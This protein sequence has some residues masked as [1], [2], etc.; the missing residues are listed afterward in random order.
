[1]EPAP[2]YDQ[3]A[4]PLLLEYEKWRGQSYRPLLPPLVRGL[5]V[6][7]ACQAELARDGSLFIESLTSCQHAV[8]GI[9]V[10]WWEAR[11][12]DG[13]EMGMMVNQIK[14]GLDPE[15]D[16]VD[17]TLRTF[18]CSWLRRSR[19]MTA[20]HVQHETE[21]LF[22]AL[23]AIHGSHR[24]AFRE[25][26]SEPSVPFTH[27]F[28]QLLQRNGF[29]L[30]G[31]RYGRYHTWLAFLL[32][33]EFMPKGDINDDPTAAERFNVRNLGHARIRAGE[34]AARRRV[35]WSVFQAP[36]EAHVVSR[37]ESRVRRPIPALIDPSPWITKRSL[38]GVPFYL[39]DIEKKETVKTEGLPVLPKYVAI[40]HTWGRW[41]LHG[42]DSD[43]AVPG[44]PW[45]VP[46]NT[47]FDVE[48]LPEQFLEQHRRGDAG[49]W[50][51]A[52]YIWFDLFCIPQDMTNAELR[53][54]AQEEIRTQAAIFRRADRAF[55][56]L[57]QVSDWEGLRT[58]IHWIALQN[59]RC[60]ERE[61]RTA[62][63]PPLEDKLTERIDGMEA[64]MSWDTDPDGLTTY[65]L[66]EFDLPGPEDTVGT[67]APMATWLGPT[68]PCGWFTSL[69]T[70]Q[71]YFLR[72]DMVL[73]DRNW[74]PCSL[75]AS[76]A[77]PITV[78]T[79]PEL[80][81]ELARAADPADAPALV[82][83]ACLATAP[84]TPGA[85][86]RSRLALLLAAQG[87]QCTGSRAEGI[88]AA[89]DATRWMQM[90]PSAGL[91]P[92]DDDHS[93][94]VLGLY[95]VG[96]LREVRAL[97]GGSFF[98]SAYSNRTCYWD[99]F[100]DDGGGGGGGGGTARVAGTMLPF[101][102]E[103]EG[104]LDGKTAPS[105]SRANRVVPQVELWQL[106]DQGQVSAAD[107]ALVGT[108]D[109]EFAE[110]LDQSL[111]VAARGFRDRSRFEFDREVEER[112]VEEYLRSLD[113]VP[114]RKYA[115][116]LTFFSGIGFSGANGAV[117]V[118][119]PGPEHRGKHFAKLQ[120]FQVS[121][122]TPVLHHC[123]WEGV[124]WEVW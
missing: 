123:V 112:D 79:I 94:W 69:W 108:T 8:L 115:V 101:G 38:T 70:L 17:H 84:L 43:A 34:E 48:S 80:C 119:L 68:Q 96:F 25:P 71:E 73:I 11:C 62:R 78:D 21:V 26:A 88:A 92:G 109:P 120:D 4:R 59:L 49:S 56:W 90:R 54:R 99:V 113:W 95:P 23:D 89:L 82:R 39:W 14:E 100:D 61:R 40:S 33:T 46:R 45:K 110:G 15:L 9:L 118:E 97:T 36:D 117:L 64:V 22:E 35:E 5:L 18:L 83:E 106:G 19:S 28:F 85:M 63:N 13:S 103:D 32:G 29:S 74:A 16:H 66:H 31:K 50:L 102:R 58:A 121:Q 93:G 1:M 3:D 87:R 57:N 122:E 111:R 86:G 60:A 10:E 6:F 116:I 37:V 44:V 104:V 55:A 72:P 30:N 47:R 75:H 51:Q 20:S 65:L 98:C 81:R 107:I 12:D 42:Q 27:S 105:A 52:R 76:G 41:R 53:A 91:P 114:G 124:N 24:C 7:A 2:Q 67:P 77:L